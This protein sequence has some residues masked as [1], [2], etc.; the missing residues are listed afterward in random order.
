MM[1]TIK[2]KSE[3]IIQDDNDDNDDDD[4]DDD[5]EDEEEEDNN[6][7]NDDDDDNDEENDDDNEEENKDEKIIIK[8]KKI[9]ESFNDNILQ[10][11]EFIIL[12]K[13]LDEEIDNIDKEYKLKIKKRN[14]IFKQFLSK[15]S[16]LEAQL[17]LLSS[18]AYK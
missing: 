17:Q 13:N 8:K 9:K 6:E 2:K 1:S 3:D 12:I 5:D 18:S 14:T 15:L 16:R 7:E 11:N 10:L 4:N